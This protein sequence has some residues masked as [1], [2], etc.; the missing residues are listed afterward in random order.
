VADKPQC[1]SQTMIAALQRRS[2]LVNWYLVI[3][4][5]LCW[6]IRPIRIECLQDINLLLPAAVAQS[7]DGQFIHVGRLS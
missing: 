6:A 3:G 4:E 1:W 2:Q 5:I 7:R